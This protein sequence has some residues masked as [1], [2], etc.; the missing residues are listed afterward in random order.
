[1]TDD[2]TVQPGSLEQAGIKPSNQVIDFC[3]H[4]IISPTNFELQELRKS[5]ER[6]TEIITGSFHV[7][8]PKISIKGIFLRGK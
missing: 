1:M 6:L 2:F 4:P 3:T 7:S 8:V 5:V